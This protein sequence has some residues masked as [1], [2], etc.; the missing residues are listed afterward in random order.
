MNSSL[1]STSFQEDNLIPPSILDTFKPPLPK[2]EIDPVEQEIT[3]LTL[4]GDWQDPIGFKY[5]P[6]SLYLILF[7]FNPNERV[8][9]MQEG[10]P[11]KRRKLDSA[12]REIILRTATKSNERIV[13]VPKS[14]S[15][16]AMETDG[17]TSHEQVM[18]DI[19]R[20]TPLSR[21]TETALKDPSTNVNAGVVKEKGVRFVQAE[22]KEEWKRESVYEDVGMQ[23]VVFE[24]HGMRVRDVLFEVEEW[25]WRSTRPGRDLKGG[26]VRTKRVSNV[27][28]KKGKG[29]RRVKGKKAAVV[30][31]AV[32]GMVESSARAEETAKAEPAPTASDKEEGELS[33]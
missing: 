25:T 6:M 20:E 9:T 14:A 18:Y 1:P 17:Q 22:P 8:Q 21:A 30:S 11:A 28:A 4:S 31:T 2:P 19:F 13:L 3:S 15:N 5:A 10:P 26:I 27:S 23:D 12:D 16:G 29:K 32:V 33:G 7:A 24:E